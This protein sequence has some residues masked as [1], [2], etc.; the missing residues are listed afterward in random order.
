MKIIN[1]KL[2]VIQPLVIIYL[3]QILLNMA[4]FVKVK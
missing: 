3:K 1:A 2:I 4:S